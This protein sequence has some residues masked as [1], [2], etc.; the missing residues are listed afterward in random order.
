MYVHFEIY[1]LLFEGEKILQDK[2]NH[3]LLSV[4]A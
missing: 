2:L 3:H 4:I 1:M